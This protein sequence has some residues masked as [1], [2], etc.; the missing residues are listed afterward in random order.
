MEEVNRRDEQTRKAKGVNQKHSYYKQTRCTSTA[1]EEQ[2]AMPAGVINRNEDSSDEEDYYGEEKEIA[3]EVQELR[4]AAHWINQ[5]GWDAVGEGR[6]ISPST[7]KEIDLRLD[8][9]DVKRKLGAGTGA[10]VAT[11]PAPV[12][13]SAV[14]QDYAL[15]D[16]DPTQRA[17]A[18]RA[19]AWGAELVD[20]Y[21]D[22]SSTGKPRAL[23]KMRSWLGGSAGSGKSTTL[24]T[25]VHHLRLLF[26]EKQVEAT[27]ELTAYTGVA[28]FN[29]GFGAKTACTSFRVFPKAKWHNE[30]EGEAFRKL[31]QQ[32]RSVVLLIVDEISFIGRA[33]F[34]K[35]HFRLQQAKRRFFSEAALDPNDYTFGNLSIILVGDFGQL[36]PIEDWSMCDSEATWQTCPKNL[37]HMWRHQCH[38]KLLMQTFDE[39]VI[40]NKIHR[41]EHDMWWTESCLRLRDATCTKEADYDQWREH[42]LDRG[43]LT[44][45]QKA[46]FEN[47]AVWLCARC[48]DVGGRNGRKLAHM[49]E[50]GKLLIH[51]IHS[52]NSTKTARKQPS[53][54][55]DGLRQRIH[56]VRGCKV[57][58][59]RNVAYLYGLANGTRGNLVGVVYGPGGVGTFPEALVV[60]VP[61]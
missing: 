12:Q 41:S 8:W 59:T 50:D 7:G 18:D 53:S 10:D 16:L 54:A 38:G 2:S 32:W 33:F 58:L 20:V 57:M 21:K 49:A 45:E 11:G 43:H 44:V 48:E 4:A 34:A 22:V 28:A 35:M 15:D 26:Q 51:Q 27:V 14:S 37:R 13:R 6:A 31:E 39:A 40:L 25:I 42:D 47:E 52:E 46:Y 17:F 3:K 60:E 55:F 56:L 1:Q 24:K 30:L 29:I 9:A 19:L 61:N 5:E 36:E 23:P